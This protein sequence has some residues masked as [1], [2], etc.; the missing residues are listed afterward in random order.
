MAK[1]WT[2]EERHKL[3]LKMDKEFQEFVQ[4]KTAES[5]A[6]P[7]KPEKSFEEELAVS[8]KHLFKSITP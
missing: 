2:D 8:R 3:A 1:K 4:Q 5:A 7:P 6:K